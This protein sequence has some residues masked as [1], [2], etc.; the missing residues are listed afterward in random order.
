[1]S[2]PETTDPKC[3]AAR[4][5]DTPWAH[6]SFVLNAAS[7]VLGETGGMVPGH[8]DFNC[9]VCDAISPDYCQL[10]QCRWDV[11]DPKWSGVSRG[12]IVSGR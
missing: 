3:I 1:M 9:P 12:E 5:L 11:I 6:S 7:E 2:N 8:S 10:R 4:I